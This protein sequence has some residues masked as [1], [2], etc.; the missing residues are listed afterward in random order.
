MINNFK[1]VFILAPHTDDGELGC[2]ATI[3]KLIKGGSDVYYLA[4]STAK[5][6]V[7]EGYPSDILETEVRKA[8]KVLG[9]KPRNLFIFDYAVRKLCY[10]RQEILETLIKF[11][12]E[13]SPDLIFMPS[14]NDIHQDHDTIAREGLRA[15]KYSSILGYELLWNNLDFNTSCFVKLSQ[16]DVDKKIKA[17]KC[18]RSQSKRPYM[19]KNFL[20][21]H[22]HTRGVQINSKFAEAFEVIRLISN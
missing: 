7:P 20:C 16:E 21:A 4:F 5:E 18:Y 10:S 1:K 2:G 22:L 14:L 13:Y 9:I 3:S 19:T 12:N 17:L 8:T 11:R 6:S 15:F